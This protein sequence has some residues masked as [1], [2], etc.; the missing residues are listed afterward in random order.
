M[1]F[2]TSRRL[3]FTV[4]RA[5]L[6]SARD[7]AAEFD[8]LESLLTNSHLQDDGGGRNRVTK[9]SLSL[10]LAQSLQALCVGPWLQ[11]PWTASHVKILRDESLRPAER[12]DEAYLECT[13]A[14]TPNEKPCRFAP[15]NRFGPR[16]LLR[17]LLV[18][19]AAA[20]RH[21]NGEGE[22]P[23]SSARATQSMVRQ[24]P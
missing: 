12:L 16:P 3:W 15:S 20:D 9:Y 6:L 8:P 5:E 14:W 24:T 13:V 21:R 17:V 18:L 7:K 23:T 11:R 19:H 4:S 10:R 1:S 22:L 2:D